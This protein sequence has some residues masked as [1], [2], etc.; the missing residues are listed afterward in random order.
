MTYPTTKSSGIGSVQ[1]HPTPVMSSVSGQRSSVST[2]QGP[3]VYSSA[4]RASKTTESTTGIL[5]TSVP[6]PSLPGVG[7]SIPPRGEEAKSLHK[8]FLGTNFLIGTAVGGV[9]LLGILFS[10]L[11]LYRRR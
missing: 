2:L 10:M 1:S 5:S 8:L 6:S 7:S 11:V 3:T 4:I 9:V